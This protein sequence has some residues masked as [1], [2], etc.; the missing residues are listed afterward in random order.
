MADS[1]K[2]NKK[3]AAKAPKKKKSASAKAHSKKLIIN[4]VT[5]TIIMTIV[6]AGMISIQLGTVFAFISIAMLPGIV[7]QITDG[8]P[9]RFA[10]KT[11]MAFNVA[12][13]SPQIEAIFSSGSPDS[14]AISLF[15]NP[16]VWLLIYGFA[17]FGWGVVFLVPRI[18]HLYLEI[19]AKY[20]T[21]KLAHFQE[22]LVEEWG[23]EVRK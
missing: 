11:V 13:I 16:S 10:S 5:V 17:A 18:S 2:D 15:S 19:T 4:L 8:R 7:A 21:K 9:G 6:A 20:T 1:K 3:S 22:K 23:D 12:G 14:T